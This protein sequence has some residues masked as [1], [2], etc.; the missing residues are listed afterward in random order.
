MSVKRKIILGLSYIALAWALMHFMKHEPWSFSEIAIAFNVDRSSPAIS[1][2][3]ADLKSI[4]NAGTAARYQLSKNLQPDA[5]LV[6]RAVEYLYPIRIV[7]QNA[8]VFAANTEVIPSNCAVLAR[9]ETVLAY[10]CE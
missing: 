10:V 7:S 9:R 3:V 1:P 2:M 6:Q 4:A 5:L 8:P